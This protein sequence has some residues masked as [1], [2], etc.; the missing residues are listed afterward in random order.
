MTGQAPANLPATEAASLL[1]WA[2][3]T[4]A[5]VVDVPVDPLQATRLT[6]DAVEGRAE[7]TPE[8]LTEL[9]EQVLQASRLAPARAGEVLEALAT[10]E[11]PI[12]SFGAGGLALTSRR[13]DRIEVRRPGAGE[14]EWL[15][16]AQVRELVAAN[17]GP[18]LTAAPAAPLQALAAGGHDHENDHGHVGPGRR[19]LALMRLERDDLWVIFVYAVVVGLLTLA[20]P[21]AVQSLVGTVAFGTLLQ[22][23]VVLSLIFLLALGFQATVRAM[24][25]RVVEGLQQRFFART[26]LDLAWRLPRVKPEAVSEGFSPELVNR[27]FD[28]MAVQKSAQ[29]L[30]TD[31]IATVL[32][33][34]IGLLVLGFY[35]PALFAFALLLLLL[36]HGVLLVPARR[37]LRT[38]VDES[39]AKYAVAAWLEELARPG[40][41]FK[42]RGGAQLAADR[43]DAL[44]RRYLDARRSHFE[45]LFGQTVGVLGLQVAASAAL[46]GLGGWLVVQR[47]LT[48]GQL[49]AA[50]LIVAAVTSSVAKLG[51]LLDSTYD[52]LTALKKLGVLLD[53]PVEEPDRGEPV[54]GQ[55]PMRVEV[56]GCC[57]TDS[58]G[59]SFDVAAGER[60]AIAGALAHPVAHWLAGLSLPPRGV[61]A[62]NGVETSRA[63]SQ[64]LREDVV[65]IEG[66]DLFDG[67][68]LDNVTLGRSAVTT[69]EARAAL[70][71]VGLLDELRALPDGLDTRVHHGGAPLTPSQRTRL[72]VARAIAGT[73]RL[74]VVDES[75]EA[76]EP[77]ARRR[78]VS[79]LTRP[80]APWTLVALVNDPAAM[81]ARACGRRLAVEELAGTRPGAEP[82]VTAS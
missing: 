77:I 70:E 27:F 81:L 39:E 12:V 41:A 21:V 74:I 64:A 26:T 17:P 10:V 45:V 32:Q 79:A 22:P 40:S 59:L 44:T 35:H 5:S 42:S 25:T 67:T 34:G 8:A 43:A 18:W 54:P 78:C 2:L 15:T 7:F 82:E 62:L 33:V 58:S 49:I 65:L 72:L 6:R 68:V 56:R 69:S 50:E 63:R 66:G 47:E 28:V 38:S 73:P 9:L 20:T 80:G 16:P 57:D 37:G 60:V 53:L 48:L 4:L 46:L 23:I 11:L 52:L 13:G 31:G 75:L 19:L 14:A 76:I 3:E 24:Q 61:V 36:I 51:K 1:A 55:G 30:L 71:R 29:V